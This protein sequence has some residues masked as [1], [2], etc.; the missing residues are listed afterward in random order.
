MRTLWNGTYRGIAFEVSHTTRPDYSYRDDGPPVIIGQ[1]DCWTFYLYL[2]L[3]ALPDDYTGPSFWLEPLHDKK[4][5]P[6]YDYSL[7]PILSEIDW[8]HGITFYSKEHGFEGGSQIIK[9]GC[10]YQHHW[11]RGHF[12]DSEEVVS[13]AK[14]AIDSLHKLVPGIKRRCFW[15]GGYYPECEGELNGESFISFDGKRASEAMRKPTE[16]DGDNRMEAGTAE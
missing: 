8:H 10:D 3:S 7:H 9:A 11:D 6:H 12:Y 5:R 14:R 16:A 13:D 1:K 4:G 2:N 15:N